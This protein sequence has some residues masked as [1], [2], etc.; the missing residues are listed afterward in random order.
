M[1]KWIEDLLMLQE[2]D[3]RIRNLQLR[4]QM[5]PAEVK[6]IEA[7]LAEEKKKLD[8]AK[9]NCLKH[10]LDMK[11]IESSIKE[12]NTETQKLQSQSA[13]VKKND[14]Y[15]ALLSEIENVRKKIGGFETE[16]LVLMDKIE[17]EKK[18][19]KEK[20]KMYADRQKSIN[21]EKE[22]LAELEKQLDNEILKLKMKCEEQKKSI[23]PEILSPYLRL[24]SKGSSTPFVVASQG[25]CGNCHLKLTPQTVNTARKE[26]K[27]FCDNCS[28]MIY[29][30][31]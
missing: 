7:E 5:L 14:E 6:K 11:K 29:F 31:E 17:D 30:K 28:H 21:E 15:R 9:E 2:T 16:Q 18:K 26:M 3:L 27:A 20:E 22:G 25:I 19:F 4:L 13:M 23:A 10:D 1:K 12:K 8:L 24:L